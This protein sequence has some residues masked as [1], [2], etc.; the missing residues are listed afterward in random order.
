MINYRTATPTG[1]G[2]GTGSPA[3]AAPTPITAPPSF[4]TPTQTQATSGFSFGTPGGTTL[5]TSF[6]TPK[7]I[8]TSSVT[9]TPIPAGFGG[10]GTASSTPSATTT[11]PGL[12]FGFGST[13]QASTAN[14]LPSF[15]SSPAK[16]TGITPTVGILPTTSAPAFNFNTPQQAASATPTLFNLTAAPKTINATTTTA[17]TG[18]TL[19][20][21]STTL[22]GGLSAGGGGFGIG[23]GLGGIASSATPGTNTSLNIQPKLGLGGVDLNASQPKATEGKQESGKIKETQVPQEIIN[24]VENL[25]AYIKDQK[26]LSSDIARSSNRKMNIQTDIKNMVCS[27]Q[28]MANDVDSNRS[29]VKNLRIDTAQVIQQVEM[30]Q[31]THETPAGLQFENTIPLQFFQELTQKYENDLLVLKSQVEITEKHMFSLSNPQRLS[32][33]DLK[34][35]IQQIHESF[36]ALAGRLYEIHQ[37]VEA[38]KEYYLNLRKFLLNE[39]SSSAS[40]FGTDESKKVET[41]DFGIVATGPTP[42]SSLGNLSFSLNLTNNNNSQ[43]QT[44]QMTKD[45]TQASGTTSFFNLQAPPMFGAKRTKP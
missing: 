30:A 44:S 34:R 20:A 13:P 29:A 41:K 5:N 22:G 23:I 26:S 36:I 42:F 27:V 40:I 33:E 4:G 28:Q 19:G 39:K 43:Q 17:S 16:I 45:S 7:P 37:K 35:G 11:A 31:R 15:G 25:K 12:N 21:G 9:T 1:F 24:T 8:T 10:F 38:Q 3:A 6:G 2:F 32:P 14:T 18:F